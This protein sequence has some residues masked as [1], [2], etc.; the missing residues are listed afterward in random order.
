M[1]TWRKALFLISLSFMF[2][3]ICIGYA[4]VT[5]NLTISGTAD[6]KPPDPE[7]IYI[8]HVAIHSYNC[9]SPTG[10]IIVL[11]TNLQSSYKVNSQ[12]ATITYQIT[13]HNKTDM[14]YWYLGIEYVPETENNSIVNTTDGIIISTKDSLSSN[15][16]NFDNADWVPPQTERTF[17]ATYTFGSNAQGN[18]STLINFS[19]GL[20]VSSL[21]D[22]L[23]KVLNDKVS[24]FGYNYLANA[25]DEQYKENGSTVIGNVGNDKE[26]FD[27]LF[28]SSITA[29]INGEELPV[30]VM[31]ERKDVDGKANTGDSYDGTNAIA[32]CEYTVYI[33]TDILEESGSGTATVYAVSYTCDANGNWYI[34]GELYEGKSTI[35]QYENSDYA[36]DIAFDVDS[37]KAVKKTYTVISGVSYTVGADQNEGQPFDRC[38]TI[39]ELMSITGDTEFYNKVNNNSGN[40]LKPVCKI[41]YSYQ[42]VNGKFVESINE[43]NRYKEGYDQLKAA[44]D[45]LKP[46][47][48]INNGGF[49]RLENATSLSRAEL[50]YMLEDIQHAYD[51]YLAVNP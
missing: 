34:I 51:Y 47:C 22:G 3:L 32:G 42:N 44:F 27:N 26:I 23:L 12:N 7:G 8:S 35:E 17:Y 38:T 46:N 28:G 24:E 20:N 21:S 4:I 48:F 19:F 2:A 16:E 41:L 45:R 29:T 15:S 10:E 30:T 18:I 25:F 40:L 50:V 37:W 11:P 13:V 1:K 36:N 43:E 14:S 31:I 39:E 5:D 6:V 9:L 49:E 33:T